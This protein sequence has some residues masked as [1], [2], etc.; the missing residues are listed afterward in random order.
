MADKSNIT[1]SRYAPSPNK[2]SSGSLHIGFLSNGPRLY[3]KYKNKWFHVDLQRMGERASKT[4]ERSSNQN[5]QT[6]TDIK[7]HNLHEN[8]M[9]ISPNKIYIPWG[10]SQTEAAGAVFTDGIIDTGHVDHTLFLAPYK[11]SLEKLLIYTVGGVGASSFALNVNGIDG[12]SFDTDLQSNLVSTVNFTDS[13]TF[14]EG[15]RLAVQWAAPVPWDDSSETV[16]VS[17]W[18]YNVA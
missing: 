12:A 8:A 16:I 14:N 15:D 17:V 7:I 2:G 5:A 4:R 13:N 9:H 10:G 6:I 3:A 1:T 11:G 18:K